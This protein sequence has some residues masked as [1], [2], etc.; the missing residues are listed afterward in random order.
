MTG[1][2]P[3]S[4]GDKLDK[5]VATARAASVKGELAMRLSDF[6]VIPVVV[7]NDVRRAA[8]LGEAL[9]SGG[10]AVA[11]VTFR[12]TA[13]ADAI[14]V[15]CENGSL[16][17]GAGTVVTTAQVD[18]AVA[19]GARFIVCPGTSRPVIERALEH[20][21]SVLPG[22]VTPSEVMTVL[23]LGIKTCKFFPAKVF[24]GAAALKA[25]GAPFPQV[26]FVPT[27]GIQ[28]DNLAEYLSLPNVSAVGGSWMVP[29]E[30]VDAG[31]F[32]L[33]RERCA[34]AVGI[35]SRAKGA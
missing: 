31:D 8:G 6:R 29:T 7:L 12:T 16:L 22:T 13:A 17:V 1:N 2:R 27:G 11:E 30:A 4:T 34:K 3:V 28:A 25:L 5:A 21:V 15:M 9:V 14:R 19:A 23:E 24:G 10:L 20:G 18:E 26:C 33:I 32:D 35:A